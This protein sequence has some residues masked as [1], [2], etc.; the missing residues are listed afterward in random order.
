M[1]DAVL[2][3]L[4][5]LLKTVGLNYAF[6]LDVNDRAAFVR[7]L[8]V[9]VQLCLA[10]LPL[11]L[12][13]GG[14]LAAFLVSGHPALAGAARALV[15]LTRN[16][17]TLVQI[18]IAFFVVNMLIRETAPAFSHL[19]GPFSWVVIV[20]SLHKGVFHAEALRAGLQAVPTVTL[21]AARSLGLSRFQVLTRVRFPLALRFALPALVNNTV[22]LVKM[23]ALASAIAVGDVTYE[24]IMIWSHRDTVL[25][26]MILLLLYFGLLTW[27]VS[28][29]GRWLET[30]LRM[31]GYGH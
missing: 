17:P 29:A 6:V 5:A 10:S 1:S 30:R 14:I 19:I 8:G 15:E 13:V 20:I 11:S 24:A 12:G 22:D 26:L 18:Y 4:V 7:G 21:E 23:T 25:E 16:T 31:H 2:S 3:D 28:M 27:M 9:T